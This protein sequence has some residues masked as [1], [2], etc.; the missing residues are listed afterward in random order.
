[1]KYTKTT[2]FLLA[3]L[4]LL[5][6][7]GLITVNREGGDTAAAETE[8][9]FGDMPTLPP[10]ETY[11]EVT[12]PDGEAVAQN[13]LDALPAADLDGRTVTFA[14]AEES[15]DFLNDEEG[16]YL[17]AVQIRSAMVTNKYNVL[18]LF[19]HEEQEA[20]L[21]KAE[22]AKYTNSFYSDFLVIR[23]GDLGAYME[24]G[25]LLNL[26]SL[27]Y[28]DY[29]APYYD[30]DAMAQ[31]TLDGVVYGALGD[32]TARFE[33]HVCLYVNRELVSIDADDVRKGDFTWEVFLSSLE[34]LPEGTAKAVSLFDGE[35]AASLSFLAAGGHYLADNGQGVWRVSCVDPV[36]EALA[37]RFSDFFAEE[38]PTPEEGKDAFSLFVE[39]KAAYAFATLDEID[40]L[41]TPGFLW[42]IL[43]LP[44]RSEEADYRTPMTADA[45]LIVGMA[46][47]SNIDTMGLVLNAL[48]AAT[49][50]Y[51]YEVYYREALES[52]ITGIRT[53]DMMDMLRQT[54]VYD[55]G[56]LLSDT[57]EDLRKGTRNAFYQAV[58]REKTFAS[59]FD[60]A[61]KALN[62]YLDGLV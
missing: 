58:M 9:T 19:L 18:P 43:P 22:A 38:W 40:R 30:A 28:V 49:G 36:T 56:F 54:R 31:F 27:P 2:A 45:P 42:E 10:H 11:E 3:L 44:K 37:E 32:A 55:A 50:D 35:T 61:K 62:R 7:C 21:K 15:G 48:N 29:T 34:A 14:V 16:R 17:T 39:G 46:V 41:G 12:R 59:G 4:L 23:G 5:S 25:Y 51:F 57:S 47:G 33:N 24:G 60:A 13:R 26:N 6:S 1:M 52:Y 8:E 20:M 53:L